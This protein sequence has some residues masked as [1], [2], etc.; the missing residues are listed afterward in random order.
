M[1]A[2]IV[3][4]FSFNAF[5]TGEPCEGLLIGLKAKQ[6]AALKVASKV[7]DYSAA[8][9][10]KLLERGY[11]IDAVMLALIAREHVLLMGP[12]GNAKSMLADAILGNVYELGVKPDGTV[13]KDRS[14]YRIQMTPETTMSETHGP[15]DFKKLSDTGVYERLYDEGMLNSRNVFIDEIFDGRANSMRN[16]LG[17]LAERAH[18]QGPR[19]IPGRIETVVAAT[20]KYI[21]EVYE[22]V[23]DDGPKALLDRFAFSAFVPGE[24][25][26]V[27][28]YVNLIRN[29]RKSSKPLPELTFQDLEAI[30]ALVPEVDVPEHV[31][32]FLSLLSYR[33]KAETEAMEQ[34]ALK[35]YKQALRSG[36]EPAPPYRATKY[37]SPRTLSKAAAIL[38]AIV[39]RDFVKSGGQRPLKAT[40]EDV[41]K[42][43]AF[44]TLNGPSDSFLEA[45]L[46]RSTNPHEKGQLSAIV[47]ERQVFRRN[48]DQ[49]LTEVNTGTYKYALNDLQLEVDAAHTAA[50]KETV[51]RK[52]LK[53]L[54]EMEKNDSH[55]GRQ[56]KLTGEHIGQGV[57]R[58]YLEDTL[59]EM[60]GPKYEE[61]VTG[62][63]REIEEAKLRAAEEAKLAAEVRAREERRKEFERKRAEEE[64]ARK[65]AEA[66]AEAEAIATKFKDPS[67]FMTVATHVLDHELPQ[68][69]VA[70]DVT[71]S[72]LAYYDQD[73]HELY[74][75]HSDGRT[76]AV[77][78]A[79]NTRDDNLKA[80]L[81]GQY[82]RIQ[83]LLL[84]DRDHIIAFTDAN[85][86]AWT[87]NVN[88][89]TVIQEM[90]LGMSVSQG[91]FQPTAT[92]NDSFM[93]LDLATKRVVEFNWKTGLRKGYAI[94]GVANVNSGLADVLTIIGRQASQAIM[95][96]D[97]KSMIIAANG[98]TQ[99]YKFDLASGILD[100]V[101]VSPKMTGKVTASAG[102]SEDGQKFYGYQVSGTQLTITITDVADP[103]GPGSSIHTVQ[104]PSGG[105]VKHVAVLE[106]GNLA[107][108]AN[109]RG[110]GFILLDLNTNT[111]L[112]KRVLDGR[113]W[114]GM[115]YAMANNTFVTFEVQNNQ[116]H[117]NMIKQ[118]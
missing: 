2:L 98:T 38:K 101:G 4:V 77:V 89:A 85:N 56:T 99:I 29:V 13:T 94:K 30:R 105:E 79:N 5:A 24:F 95:S 78:S 70:R 44:F 31:A 91:S 36:E 112:E 72:N 117:L 28:S 92:T 35:T 68:N 62:T 8:L 82:G 43:E 81:T 14:Y 32:Q 7:N 87:V 116:Y 46:E 58:G 34:A 67:N 113:D 107:V 80:L 12:P 27:D 69:F 110:E 65:A 109:A 23:G 100:Y 61:V 104:L 114:A 17:L 115:V 18:A 6:D 97:G 48:F 21:S 25:E 84:A 102:H 26:S 9:N 108:V 73:K 55:G 53:M 83:R 75:M 103:T 47:Q 50:E 52:L 59:S 93:Y 49:V 64:A 1:C 66:K 39:V 51:A 45:Q 33:V 57:V 10:E 15:L 22:R 71:N 40:I 42:L 74:V 90:A 20:N 19:I 41:R 11:I 106:G 76:A 88:D 16:I 96:K 54:F 3:A 118:R 37:H 63:L 111:V 60:L 86:V